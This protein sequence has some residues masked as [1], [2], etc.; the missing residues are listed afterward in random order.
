MLRNVL[1][2]VNGGQQQRSQCVLHFT[3][4]ISQCRSQITLRVVVDEQNLLP[5]SSQRGAQ[6]QGRRRFPDAALGICNGYDS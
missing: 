4:G 1:R 3:G 2:I 5:F 6:V